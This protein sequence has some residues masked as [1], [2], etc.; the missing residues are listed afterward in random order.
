MP[1]GGWCDEDEGGFGSVCYCYYIECPP[2]PLLLLQASFRWN[3]FEF[4]YMCVSMRV[5]VCAFVY[6]RFWTLISSSQGSEWMLIWQLALERKMACGCVHV[7]VLSCLDI[8]I[9]KK[10]KTLALLHM[11][12]ALFFFLAAFIYCFVFVCFFKCNKRWMFC[13]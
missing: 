10:V 12:L 9:A 1:L 8:V 13:F 7:C 6:A 11:S 5:Y 3:A 4:A 2:P